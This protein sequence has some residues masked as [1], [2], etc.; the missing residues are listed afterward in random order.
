MVFSTQANDLLQSLPSPVRAQWI[1]ESKTL[2]LQAG[3][4]ICAASDACMYFPLTAVLAWTS[5]LSDGSSSMLALVGHESMVQL[6]PYREISQELIVVHP[7]KVLQLRERAIRKDEQAHLHA[8]QLCTQSL[9]ALIAQASQNLICSQNHR[10]SQRLS[11]LLKG[12]V[13]RMDSN[14]IHLTHQQLACL[15]GTRR[16]RVSYALSALQEQGAIR[17]ARG[18]LQITD[19]AALRRQLCE[20]CGNVDLPS[21]HHKTLPT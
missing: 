13:D 18:C 4:Q 3:D 12:I 14:T 7:G 8:Q 21:T 5:G 2:H 11:R 15:L 19:S 10:L 6:Q 17:C 9:H 16:E 1:L 20:C